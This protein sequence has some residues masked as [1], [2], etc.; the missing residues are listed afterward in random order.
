MRLRRVSILIAPAFL[1]LG[2]Q[3]GA[4]Q[5]SDREVEVHKNLKLIEETASPDVPAELTAQYQ[6]FLPIFRD[7]LKATTKD[8]PDDSVLVIRVAVGFKEVGAAK[9][10]RAQARV[11]AFCRNSRQ[12][13]LGNFLLYSYAT[14]GPVNKEETEQF[15]KKQI[16][17]PLDCFT[18]SKD[19]ATD[20]P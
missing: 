15:L 16:L 5:T 20:K 13:Y 7:A 9:V 6:S 2:L 3:P 19:T 4:P 12:E 18:G 14:S 8:Q 17:D 11:T 10:K 1:F